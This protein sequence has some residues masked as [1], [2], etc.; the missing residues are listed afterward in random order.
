MSNRFYPETGFLIPLI[1]SQC[2]ME[3]MTCRV[4]YLIIT[5]HWG[6]FAVPGWKYFDWTDLTNR[7]LSCTIQQEEMLIR[8]LYMPLGKIFQ[9]F[10]HHSGKHLILN[11]IVSEGNLTG[12]LKHELYSYENKLLHVLLICF[13]HLLGI[14]ATGLTFKE[15]PITIR[16]ST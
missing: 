10:W 9:D 15:E 2:R 3:N 12:H 11:N 14:N 16:R 13:R 1:R 5:C 7:L 6:D 4:V 8:Q